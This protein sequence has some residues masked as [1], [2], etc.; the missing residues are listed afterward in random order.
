MELLI[1]TPNIDVA[2]A[3]RNLSASL[4]ER[5]AASQILNGPDHRF[6]GDTAQFLDR[7]KNALYFSMILTYGQGMALLK[8]ASATYGFDLSLEAV[9]RIWRGGCIIRAALLEKIRDAYQEEPDLLN[10]LTS[11]HFAPLL[12]DRQADIRAVVG[13]AIDFGVPVLGFMSSLAYYDSYRSSWLPANLIQ[14]QRD[15]FGAHTYER[16]DMSG[17][18]H[19]DWS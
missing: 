8:Q 2:V 13:T 1:P 6:Q 17:V 11:P 12:M 14:A 10:L 16:T 15:Y 18:F 19:T 4:P 3:M 9:A 7:L 5:K